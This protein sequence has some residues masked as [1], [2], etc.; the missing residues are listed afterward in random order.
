MKF[1]IIGTGFIMP[2]HVDAINKVGGKIRNIVND[3]YNDKDWE[4]MVEK[5]DADYIVILTP[6]DLHFEMILKSLEQGKKVLCEKPLVVNYSHAKELV[7]L[8]ENNIFTV[9]QLRYHPLVNKMK[10]EIGEGKHDIE[11]DISVY[12]D[13]KYHNGWKGRRERSGGI[14]FNLGIHYF[15]TFLCLFGKPEKTTTS[16]LADRVAEGTMES[17]NYNCRWRVSTNEKRETQRRLFKIDGKEYNF[18]SQDNL[19]YENLHHFVYRDLLKGKGL[20]SAEAL[21]SIEL[22]EALY[23]N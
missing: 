5:T 20:S 3:A 21:K 17:D 10:S 23:N 15:D 2:R 22:V 16:L 18:S 7:K 4:T 13:Q 14:C 19:S 9:L 8:D 11:I 1:S 6:N 12:R